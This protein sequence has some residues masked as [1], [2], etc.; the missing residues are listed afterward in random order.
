MPISVKIP[1][2]ALSFRSKGSKQATELDFVAH[3]TD[4]AGRIAAVVR[5]TIPLKLD[6]TTAGQVSQKSIQYDT[7]LT[8]AP[9]STRCV[10]SRARMARA[11]RVR[12]RRRSRFRI[13]LPAASCG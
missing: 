13:S 4:C 3:V 6:E 7:G 9:G 11:K 8:L 10:S 1:G 5:D 2:S 12:S